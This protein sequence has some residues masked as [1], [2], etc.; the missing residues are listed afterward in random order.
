M[1]NLFFTRLLRQPVPDVYNDNDRRHLIIMADVTYV[2]KLVNLF[3][4]TKTRKIQ[5]FN[6]F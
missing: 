3:I 4:R 5:D 2:T 1:S 6:K